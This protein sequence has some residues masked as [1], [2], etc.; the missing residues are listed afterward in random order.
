[1]ESNIAH[2]H[3]SKHLKIGIFCIICLF[4]S[5]SFAIPYVTTQPSIST[6]QID[7]LGKT[8]QGNAKKRMHAWSQLIRTHAQSSEL[9]QLKATNDFFNLF[10]YISETSYQ[11]EEDHWKAPDEFVIDGGGDCE[12]FAIAKYFT[13]LSMGVSIDKLRITYVKSLKFNQ[14]HMVLT[15]YAEPSSDPLVLD[16][17]VPEIFPASKRT[18]LVPVYS[19]NGQGL[20]LAKSRGQQSMVGK[21]SG[22]SKWNQVIQHIEQGMKP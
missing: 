5:S 12:D 1:M 13:L 14:A 2:F 15:Y 22:L 10:Q 11:G 17:L 6:D 19:F 21:A 3:R 16:N 4:F 9:N 7:T 18:D 20:W 8:Q